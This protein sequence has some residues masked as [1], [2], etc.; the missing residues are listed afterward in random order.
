M[1]K[2]L[3]PIQEAVREGGRLAQTQILERDPEGGDN[4][5]GSGPKIRVDTKRRILKALE[6]APDTDKSE[7]GDPRNRILKALSQ[8]KKP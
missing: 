5:K 2:K 1:P 4:E 6:Q 7:G 3:T 8:D